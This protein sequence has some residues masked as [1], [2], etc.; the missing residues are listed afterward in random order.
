M[1]EVERR[2]PLRRRSYPKW[3]ALNDVVKRF[4][5]IWLVCLALVLAGC[6]DPAE[7]LYETAQFEEVQNNQAHARKLYEKIVQDYADSPA[8]I[9]AKERLAAMSVSPA[10]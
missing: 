10:N 9:K 5:M 6:S 2:F 7:E 3:C 4:T 8:A 1:N